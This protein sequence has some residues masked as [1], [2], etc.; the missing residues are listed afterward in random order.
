MEESLLSIYVPH[1]RF[2][3]SSF[4]L[5]FLV[6][7]FPFL[8]LRFYTD[9]WKENEEICKLSSHKNWKVLY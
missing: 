5:L 6:S 7:Q 1:S 8:F 9:K 3:A 4:T 2:R